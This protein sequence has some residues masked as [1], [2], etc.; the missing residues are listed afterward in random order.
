MATKFSLSYTGIG[1]VQRRLPAAWQRYSDAGGKRLLD[2]G[3]ACLQL[4]RVLAPVRTGALRRS[5]AVRQL[6]L[7][8]GKGKA[9]VIGFGSADV[10]YAMTVHETHPTKSKF[11]EQAFR[12]LAAGMKARLEN[13]IKRDVR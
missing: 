6:P 4:A 12:L 8:S 5:G 10:P 2:E 9:V 1:T 13:G 7:A 3:R 11:L